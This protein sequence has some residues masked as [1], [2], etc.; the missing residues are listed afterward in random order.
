MKLFMERE[1]QH[2]VFFS[3]RPLKSLLVFNHFVT[4]LILKTELTGFR[5]LHCNNNGRN[6]NHNNSVIFYELL[7]LAGLFWFLA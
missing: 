1:Y 7:I 3:L 6:S 4:N 2:C 5:M